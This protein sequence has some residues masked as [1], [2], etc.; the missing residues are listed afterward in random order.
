MLTWCMSRYWATRMDQTRNAEC[1]VQPTGAK[2]GSVSFIKTSTPAPSRWRCI[3]Q[4]RQPS[5]RS[6]G[7]RGKDPGK[8]ER[9]RDQAAVCSSQLMGE[10]PG[11]NSPMGYPL[12]NKDL[13]E[14]ELRLRPAIQRRCTQL[15]IRHSSVASIV[16]TMPVK[17]GNAQRASVVC[18]RVEVTLQK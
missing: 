10:Q 18:G 6:Y 2:I 1:F 16:P 7:R 8:M 15:L 11:S 5:M 12:S 17:V 9:V 14:S 4:N 3:H 13:G